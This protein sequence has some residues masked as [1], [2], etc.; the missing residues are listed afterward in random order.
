MPNNKDNQKSGSQG[1]MSGGSNREFES[2]GKNMGSG[3]TQSAGGYGKDTGSQ[4]NFQDDNEMTT[5]GGREG[6]FSDSNRDKEAQ[7]SPGS[8]RPSEE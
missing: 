4:E 3:Q 2:Q 7:W 6:Q 1:S 8:S 5:A